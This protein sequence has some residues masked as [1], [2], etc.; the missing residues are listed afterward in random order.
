MLSGRS[1]LKNGFTIV[2][3]LIVI[4]VI[5]VLAAITIV[6]YNG[7]QNRA[8]RSSISSDLRN[9]SKQLAIYNIDQN[10]YPITASDMQTIMLNINKTAY[11]ETA[12]SSGAIY[13]VRTDG[14]AYSITTRV[15]SGDMIYYSSLTDKILPYTGATITPQLC[16]DSGINNSTHMPFRIDGTWASWIK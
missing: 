9:I 5:G 1:V 7:I 6:A 10:R 11:T 8:N 2:E 3:L 15:R 4:V 16:T 12:T 14:T 13:C